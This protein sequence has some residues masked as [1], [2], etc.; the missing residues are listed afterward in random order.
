MADQIILVQALH[1]VDD[2]AV[3]LVVLPAV[4][5]VAEPVVGGLPAGFY[6]RPRGRHQHRPDLRLPQLR[7]PGGRLR[8]RAA[9]RHRL[10]PVSFV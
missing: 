2:G 6:A 9:D 3:L 4:E 1:S 8:P 10:P 5:D 7:A